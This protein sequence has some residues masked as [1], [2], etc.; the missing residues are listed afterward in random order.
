MWVIVIDGS[1]LL[2]LFPGLTPLNV[3]A[4]NSNDAP[5]FPTDLLGHVVDHAPVFSHDA[6]AKH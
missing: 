2:I 3:N 6:T 5:A 1:L 4:N